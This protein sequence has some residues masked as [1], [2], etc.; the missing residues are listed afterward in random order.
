VISPSGCCHRLREE[1]TAPACPDNRELRQRGNVTAD[2]YAD[3]TKKY[4]LHHGR[5]T[6]P[7]T[8]NVK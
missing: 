8:F 1:A 2:E 5:I 6:L 4:G 7:T 3:F